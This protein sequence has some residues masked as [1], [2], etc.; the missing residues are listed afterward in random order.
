MTV[1][2]LPLL[3]KD[4]RL[5][6]LLLTSFYLTFVAFENI[7]V[8]SNYF[9]F[10]VTSM[11]RNCYLHSVSLNSCIVITNS[12]LWLEFNAVQNLNNLFSSKINFIDD[13]SFIYA[14]IC[15]FVRLLQ[16]NKVN[17]NSCLKYSRNLL[18]AIQLS[19]IR[20]LS[21]T[22]PWLF[23]IVSRAK[24]F[25]TFGHLLRRLA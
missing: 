3:R 10:F 13:C 8:Q 23:F 2:G 5:S 21:K 9:N 6:I 1:I 20:N 24:S 19:I 4:L 12:Y 11:N 15:I 22:W 17:I 18:F 7:L 16:N 14:L 25:K